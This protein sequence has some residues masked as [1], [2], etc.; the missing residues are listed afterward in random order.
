VGKVHALLIGVSNYWYLRDDVPLPRTFGLRPLESASL[1]V[2][3][4]AEWLEK[5][6]LAGRSLGS[7]TV[8]TAPSAIELL[9]PGVTAQDSTCTHAD[10]IREVAA[11]RLRASQD[12]SDL[13]FFYFA[14]H[15]VQRQQRDHVL[16]L[17]DFGDG[18]GGVLS[19]AFDS[20][21]LIDGMAITA[22]Y[23]NM[24]QSQI[25]FF[26]ACRMSLEEFTRFA[27][28]EPWNF[29]DWINSTN[30]QRS[31]RTAP[32]LHTA[33]DG[34]SSF[35]MSGEQSV[36][37]DALLRCLN[38]S[39]ARENGEHEDGRLRWTVSLTSLLQGLAIEIADSNDA[40]NTAQTFE[41][42]GIRDDLVLREVDPP[43]AAEI[44]VSILP[45]KA[46]ALAALE[47]LDELEEPRQNVAPVE[48]NPFVATLPAGYYTVRAHYV[49]DGPY[50]AIRRLVTPPGRSFRLALE[51]R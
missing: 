12:P 38:G 25:Y 3:R 40:W 34:S 11:W 5:Y 46:C 9:D 2:V 36:F 21:S 26:D 42:S 1:T 18:V 29:W 35:G 23:P 28:G 17:Q 44:S 24:A 27:K 47:V 45:E 37:S 49:P 4:V 41:S 13:A 7:C 51:E 43:P 50:R 22:D 15:G 16:L 14:G 48:P 20:T 6:G 19:K 10:F 8:L 30:E 32:V 39:A 31:A 33:T